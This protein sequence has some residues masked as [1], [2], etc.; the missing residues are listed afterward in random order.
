[1]IEKKQNSTEPISKSE[2]YQ[3]VY[4][5]LPIMLG[6]LPFGIAYGVVGL[7]VGLTGLETLFMSLVVFA[8]ASQFICV[9][10][11]GMGLVDFSLIL[12]TTLLVNLRHLLMGASISAYVR[13]F[14]LGRQ[15]V[16]AFAMT[17][18]SYSITMNR[19]QKKGY[20]QG[21]QL[22][23]NTAIYVTWGL[24][25]LIGI[26]VGK[27][28]PDPL[29]WGFD[30]AMPVTFLAMLIPQLKNRSSLIV[31]LVAGGVA[32]ASALYLPGKWY[33]VL[34]CLTA[35]LVGGLLEG[36]DQVEN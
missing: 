5:S 28:I 22:G 12:F 3:G 20:S 19:V 13:K 21:Y 31:C 6:V 24:A 14:S 10:M 35:S 25:T 34:A 23:A 4:D 26:V 9:T 15:A 17:D 8:G 36:G 29:A 27:Y 18:E 30:F 1:M 7:S 32:V 11:I 33:I 2:F 16:I